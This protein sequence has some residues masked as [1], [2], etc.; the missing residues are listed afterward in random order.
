ML[1]NQLQ[2][3]FFKN[4]VLSENG[5]SVYQRHLREFTWAKTQQYFSVFIRISLKPRT[6][7]PRASS[8]TAGGSRQADVQTAASS[9]V[10]GA[11][12]ALVSL[13]YR[14]RTPP[15][16]QVM[17]ELSNLFSVLHV[18]VGDSKE[19]IAALTTTSATNSNDEASGKVSGTGSKQNGEA[20]LKSEKNDNDFVLS[21]SG[22]YKQ[23]LVWIDLEMTGL[24]VEVDRILEI[25]CVIT[26]GRLTK[27]VEGPDLVINQ[28]IKCLDSMGEWCQEH[29]AA[30]G[31]EFLR[32]GLE[33]HFTYKYSF[34]VFLSSL[35]QSASLTHCKTA[36]ELLISWVLVLAQRVKFTSTYDLGQVVEFVKNHVGSQT[37]LLS[38]N[39]V[40]VDFMFLKKYMP[41]LACIFPHILVDVSSI[42][43]LCIRW[44]P[45]GCSQL[46]VA[47]GRTFLGQLV[48]SLTQANFGLNVLVHYLCVLMVPARVAIAHL[49][50]LFICDIVLL[51]A[52]VTALNVAQKLVV[53]HHVAV[54]NY[55]LK[56]LAMPYYDN[57]L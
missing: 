16:F 27:S 24:N 52:M 19:Q 53:L 30:S 47:T 2:E 56:F 48:L 25:A 32:F 40:Y 29:H 46:R 15:S 55:V 49:S 39:S 14:E 38:G 22:E 9:T 3:S 26:D 11:F 23:P 35:C 57:L 37:P 6:V 20:I 36:V 34:E 41:R 50:A 43:A 8:A 33:R 28:S 4:F 42:M 21:S 12:T 5:A 1:F 18:D 17:N 45:K 13:A 44:F 51:T 31:R 54:P 7:A 10:C